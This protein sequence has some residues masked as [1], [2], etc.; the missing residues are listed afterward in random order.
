MSFID[1]IFP[2]AG[3]L[4]G[5]DEAEGGYDQASQVQREMY[6]QGRKDLA[7]YRNFGRSYL[8]NM[9]GHIAS[10]RAKIARPTAHSVTSL[11]GYK[12]RL[13]EGLKA[14][15]NSAIARGGVL[16]GN[17]I[18]DAIGYSQ[19]YASQEYDNALDQYTRDVQVDEGKYQNK[20]GQLM[21][22]INLGYGA[23]GGSAGIA[24]NTGNALSD[25]Y[26]G[27]GKTSAEIKQFP[28]RLGAGVLGSYLGGK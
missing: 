17:A 11:P 25:L 6:K 23:A 3:S 22:L 26:V 28:L 18:R 15:E 19:D 20:F 13:D 5:G 4:F 2:G 10:R 12:F 9:Q 27:K 7:P 14:L 21:N 8:D 16:S 24:Q 1:S